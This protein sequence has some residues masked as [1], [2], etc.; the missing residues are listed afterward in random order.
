MSWSA[1]YS[2]TCF[3]AADSPVCFGVHM[4]VSHIFGRALHWL[5]EAE[6]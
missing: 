2:K 5:K 1:T 4:D 3:Q 6:H